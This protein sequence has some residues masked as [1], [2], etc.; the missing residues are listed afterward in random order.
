M[1]K[2]ALGL[3]GIKVAPLC[4][5][6]NVFGWTADEAMS[7]TLLDAFVA[8]GFDFV[9]TADGYSNW[10]PG[11]E[12]GESETVIGK[13]MTARGT[14]SRVIIATKLGMWKKTAGLR[15]ANIISACEGSLKRL[16]TDYIDL[17]QAHRDDPDTP[18]AETLEA[19]GKLVKEGKVRAIGASNFDATRL[20]A[21]LRISEEGGFPRYQTL[22]PLYNLIDRDFENALQPLCVEEEIGVFPYYA[23][24]AGFLTGKY[25]SKKDTEGKARG[26]RAETYLNDKNLA[27]LD[28]LE[29]VA[30]TRNATMAEVAI[31]WLRD[32]PSIVAP[33]ASATNLDQL[34]SLIRG[35]HL[36]LSA[37]DIAALD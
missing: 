21:A 10:A 34:Q 13:W 2:R 32:R 35:A 36:K 12:G 31:A 5:G 27:L 33:L 25:R 20:E 23:L 24:A 26:S 4:L 19:F 14:R 37:E 6:G 7:F 9:D 17:Y 3:S 8:A 28:R 16:Q 29:K 22:Q 1:E 18:Q 30:K 11:H 15:A